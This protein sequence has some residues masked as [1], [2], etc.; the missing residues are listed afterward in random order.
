MEKLG[1]RKKVQLMKFL[2]SVT[3]WGGIHSAIVCPLCV[4][5]FIFF[6]FK[7]SFLTENLYPLP[8]KDL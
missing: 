4:F 1:G 2:Y 7:V 6:K 3:I 8:I 5:I